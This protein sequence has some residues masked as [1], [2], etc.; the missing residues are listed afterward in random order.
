M[1]SE[2][3]RSIF[4]YF[5]G[6]EVVWG[7]PLRINRRLTHYLGGQVDETIASANSD[8]PVV[9]FPATERLMDAVDQ[10]FDMVPFD[11]V[12]GNG[13]RDVDR[14]RV[15]NSFSTWCD[16]VKKK[17]RDLVITSEPTVTLDPPP[18]K[19]SSVSNSRSK[20]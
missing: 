13:T 18:T 17:H 11:S 5:N 16:E 4:S 10:A 8:D 2:T 12:A 6:K 14:Y 9:S 20:G 19:S 1:F 7:D 3:D 15:L